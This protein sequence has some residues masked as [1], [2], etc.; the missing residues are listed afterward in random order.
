MGSCFTDSVGQRLMRDGFNVLVNPTGTLYN[1]ASIA[2]TLQ[3]HME[4]YALVESQGVWHH[5]MFHSRFSDD[6]PQ[7]VRERVASAEAQLQER[8][9]TPGLVGIFTFG[10]AWVFRDHN[11]I[12][13]GNCH[14]LPPSCFT[15]EMLSV[16][17]CRKHIKSCLSITSR[18]IVTVSPIRHLAD[19][20]A[21]NTLSKAT[22]I[23]ASHQVISQQINKDYF[24]AYEIM[25]DDLRDYRFY[26][27]DMVHPSEVAVD[28]IYDLFL[29][30]YC[31]P[32]TV[33]QAIANRRA[34]RRIQHKT[35]IG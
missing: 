29:A 24:P 35:I 34:T 27:A 9:T 14:K 7:V 17:E 20:F 6:D 21:G 31:S 8:L 16:E 26:A 30:T 3:G 5:P 19:G 18:T 15:R 11:S 1:P 22:L 28:Y 33:A 25:N 10:T 23:S 13:V 2:S 4:D 32:V 12:V